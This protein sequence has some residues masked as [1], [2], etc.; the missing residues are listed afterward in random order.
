MLWFSP[1]LCNSLPCTVLRRSFNHSIVNP[2]TKFPF[3][4][5]FCTPLTLANTCKRKTIRLV[6]SE[7]FC[8]LTFSLDKSKWSATWT[9][10]KTR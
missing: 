9:F 3:K 7:E 2:E 4:A 6:L 1:T 8:Y 10:V 5:V